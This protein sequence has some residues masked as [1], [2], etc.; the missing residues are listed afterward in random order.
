MASLLAEEK[1]LIVDMVGFEKEKALAQVIVY[2][3][4]HHLH[5]FLKSSPL[6]ANLV[7]FPKRSIDKRKRSETAIS[8]IRIN[9]LTVVRSTALIPASLL[10][11][12]NSIPLRHQYFSMNI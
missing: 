7:N 5:H 11:N 6:L 3:H 9:R 4:L 2:V 8:I 10:Q 1:G 12:A